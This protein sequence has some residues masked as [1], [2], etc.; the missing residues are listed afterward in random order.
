M[1]LLETNEDSLP[2]EIEQ[3]KSRIRELESR[4]NDDEL[5]KAEY[6]LKFQQALEKV[7]FFALTIDQTGNIS[8]CNEYFLKFT[9]W[10]RADVIGKKWSG[11]LSNEENEKKEEAFYKLVEKG[12]LIN[13]IKRKIFASDGS[14]RTVR[15][16]VILQNTSQ[17]ILGATLVGEDVTEKKKII[18]SLKEGNEQLQDLFEN[19]NDLIQVCTLDGEILFVNRAWKDALGYTEE[20]IFT[21]N[22]RQIVHPDYQK[23]T[24]DHLQKILEGNKADERFETV[25]TS[26][27][28]RNIHVIGGMNVRYENEK[29]IAFRGIFHD[30]TERIRAERAQNLYYKIANLTINS[31]NLEGL[32]YNIHQ[33]LKTMI[34]VNNFHVALYDKEKNVLNFPYYV[35]ENI[36]PKHVTNQRQ[37]S[38]GLTEYSLL[39]EKPTFLYEEEIL[40]LV[41]DGVI[42]LMGPSPKIWLGVPLKLENRTIGVIAVKSHSDRNK[43]KRR[44]LELLDFISGQIAIAI[45]RK[46][47]EQKIIEQTARLNAIFQSSSHLIWSYNRKRALTSFNQNYAEAVYRKTGIYPEIDLTSENPKVII[48]AGEEY[49]AFVNERYEEA[50]KGIPQHFETKSID[51]EKNEVWRETYL[52]PIF[53]PDGRIEEVSGISHDITEKKRSELAVHESEEKFRNIFE[54][55]QDIYYRTDVSGKITMI[56][57]SGCE[58]SGFSQEEMIGKHIS[59]FYINPRKQS[60]LIRQLLRTGTVLNYESNLKL[61]DGST[62]QSI[63]NIRLIFNKEGKPIAVDGVARDITYLKKASEELLKAKEI[64]E[65]SLRVKESFLANMSHEIRTPMNGVIGMIDL[66]NDTNLNQEQ[67]KYVET[68]KKSS[69]TLLRIL[70]DILDLSKIEA[71][72]MQLRLTSISIESTIEKLYALFFQQAAAKNIKLLYSIDSDVPKFILAD[73]IRLLQILS[74]FTSNSIK[75]TDKGSVKINIMLE[76]KKDTLHKIKVEVTDTGIG[77]SEEN[78]KM[79][80]ESFSQVDNSSTKSYSGTG[81]GLAISKELC[82]MMNGEVGVRTKLGEGSTFWFTFEANSSKRI[83]E[84][85]SSSEKIP[86]IENTFTNISPK[87]LVV[88][89]NNINQLV[90]SEILKKSGCEVDIA[91]N[92]M[93]AIEKV[94]NNKYDIIFMD[95]Q[96]P[97]MDGVTATREIKKL[98]IKDLA[99]IIAMTAYSMKEDK[100]RFLLG[101]M[102]DYLPKPIKA[103]NLINKVKE[104]T[105]NKNLSNVD[106]FSEKPEEHNGIFND[107]VFQ[108]LKAF[109]NPET[110]YKIYK[111][112]EKETAQQLEICK[113]SL[114]NEDFN[115]ILDN[116]H[117]LKGASGTLGI[118]K[119]EQSAT[120]IENNLK[121]KNYD[122]I[123]EDLK[124][125]TDAFLEFKKYYK[126]IIKN[127]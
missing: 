97:K 5:F 67:K 51:R 39:N 86:K 75:F 17:G 49:H 26:K 92:G 110:L 72:K 81:L 38:K 22:L 47:N 54:S 121:N 57:P 11:I 118:G 48:L 35:D 87:I 80:F 109:A 76:E 119:M 44:H 69:E 95:I 122:A 55:F 126:E 74:N 98:K 56:S 85:E 73:E 106:N 88:D 104:W 34:A 40:K 116:L 14:L 108:K 16:N 23:D 123:S 105:I 125:L 20:E 89:D 52:N 42:E 45:E 53:L 91:G 107:E 127:K 71:G 46:R 90:A 7:D 93:E 120:E 111:E 113:N 68:I 3:L 50:F 63:S 1:S 99:P 70:N 6:E 2:G 37:F 18:K 31:D 112:F 27:S 100:E 78:L 41:E 32:L 94:K 15:F 4:R 59:E 21:L 84:Q 60:K 65:R 124:R 12:G 64:A 9:G 96:M 83:S 82:R 10:K 25:F 8:Y 101:G 29:P 62:I 102:D 79:L 117:A 115:L 19:A 103:E 114:Q 66:L 24:F 77:I 33:E 58:L 43:Y 36:G 28:G 13:K 30:N 61:K